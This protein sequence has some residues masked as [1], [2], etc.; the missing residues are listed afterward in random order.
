MVRPSTHPHLSCSGPQPVVCRILSAPQP[1]VTSKA[2]PSVLAQNMAPTDVH[3]PPLPSSMATI[4]VAASSSS[5]VGHPEQVLRPVSKPVHISTPIMQG[6]HQI[7]SQSHAPPSLTSQLQGANLV[8]HTTMGPT[9][10]LSQ[11]MHTVAPLSIQPPTV[12]RQNSATPIPVAK[13]HPQPLPVVSRA[14]VV[15]PVETVNLLLPPTHLA[16]QSQPPAGNNVTA[17]MPAGVVLMEA[18]QER[19]SGPQT[20]PYTLSTA[21]YYE[22]YKSN[23]QMPYV[24]PTSSFPTISTTRRLTMTHASEVQAHPVGSMA[25]KEANGVV[26][27]AADLHPVS[28]SVVSSSVSTYSLSQ[29]SVTSTTSS[30][31]RPSILRKRMNEGLLE[32]PKPN[33]M[34]SQS[35]EA[36]VRVAESKL[37]TDVAKA[38][39]YSENGN[40]TVS[41]S[42]SSSTGGLVAASV[43]IKQ[44]PPEVGETVTVCPQPSSVS[45]METSPRKKPRKQQLTSNEL[46]ETHSTDA[47]DEFEK[48][49]KERVKKELIVREEDGVCWV[50][51]RKRPPI[52]LLNSY[53]HTWKSRHNH[54]LR[55]SDVRPKERHPTVHDLANQKGVLQKVSGW[56]VHHLC[57]Q[58]DEMVEQ[59]DNVHGRLADFL[60]KMEDAMSQSDEDRDLNKVSELIKGNLQRC[61]ITRDQ[62]KEARQQI[63]KVTD[64]KPQVTDIISKFMSK[65]GPGKRRDKNN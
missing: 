34:E 47:E 13:V 48:E 28:T 10:L 18:K 43:T 29:P 46:M 57:T 17:A 1:I 31:P 40:G 64:H 8:P 3:R 52:T 59:E 21:Y 51:T 32:S 63:L 38:L 50:P 22:P 14:S 65:R 25:A 45:I 61:R 20:G 58:L 4:Q 62:M 7:L 60:K 54:F 35:A 19:T 49:S 16:S 2:V 6:M 39:T 11:A 37:P 12:P 24:A 30:S 27:S 55:Y 23:L 56:K 41:S 36:L 9:K 33:R 42:S 15:E 5:A 44:E 53:R 26:V